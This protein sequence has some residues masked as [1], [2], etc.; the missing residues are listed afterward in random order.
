MPRSEV[1]SVPP[2]A[3]LGQ[4]G[5]GARRAPIDERD[6]ASGLTTPREDGLAMPPD[7]APHA[8]CWMAW[9]CREASWGGQLEEA[10][11]AF[12]E[13]AQAIA[14][15]E[16]V[17]MIAR[18]DLVA[19]ASLYCGPG[20]TILPMAHDDSWTRDTGPSFLLGA[21]GA[22]LAG[23]AWRFNGWGELHSD[24]G[25]DEQMAR[26]ILEH[27]GARTYE[28]GGG[29]VLEGGSIQVD[30]EGTCLASS[31]TVLDPRRNPGLGRAEAE[32]VLK[33]QLG[34]ERVLW[35]P[36]GLVGDETGGQVDKVACFARPG[37]V[38]ALATDD[39][40]DANHTGLAENLDVLRAARDARGRA[41][42]VLTL[43]PPKARKRRDGSLLALSHL[44]CYLANGALVLPRF[45]DPVDQGACKLLAQVW[46]GRELVEIDALE[47]VEGGG[48]IRGIT[49][50]QPATAAA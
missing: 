42:E 17:T 13:V 43:P 36:H 3:H 18:P 38:L 7:W 46:P 21:G 8:R 23:V 27:V 20:V 9:P 5:G 50:P 11:R 33:A 10:R 25:Q 32:D 1:A 4:R 45:G 15:F 2:F 41:L 28:A 47:I 37:A 16:P 40:A 6:E 39:R 29:V 49:L 12:A 44:S 31:A 24:H 30:G 22:G 34:V 48:G 19:T 14:R 35:L 26:R